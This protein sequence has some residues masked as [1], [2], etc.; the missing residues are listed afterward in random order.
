VGEPDLA[1]GDQ[2][3]LGLARLLTQ[4]PAAL[5]GGQQALVDLMLVEGAGR[6]QVVEVA[7]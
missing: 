1:A 7:G 5:G 6:D 4:Q 2:G 3:P